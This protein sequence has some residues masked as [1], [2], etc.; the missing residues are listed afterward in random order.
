[1]GN[2]S[3]LEY[4]IIFDEA[5]LAGQPLFL[6]MIGILERFMEPLA[7]PGVGSSSVASLD[8]SLCQSTLEGTS[9]QLGN[10]ASGLGSHPT[11][12]T[13]AL[14]TPWFI[15]K[16]NG[17]SSFRFP[18][19]GDRLIFFSPLPF[20]FLNFCTCFLFLS[21]ASALWCRDR[22][23]NRGRSHSRGARRS[24]DSMCKEVATP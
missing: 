12:C 16:R 11:C 6:G 20:H 4:L 3:L 18:I 5:S 1:M 8:A 9:L 10:L 21:L 24:L 2:R 22:N 15:M 19:S 17:I 23:F 13:F 14:S 7:L